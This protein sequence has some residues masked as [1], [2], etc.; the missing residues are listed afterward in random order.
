M[1]RHSAGVR[2]PW[3]HAPAVLLAPVSEG[4]E[5]QARHTEGGG[6]M[7]QA[8]TPTPRAE[9]LAILRGNAQTWMTVTDLAIW[10]Y[11]CDGFDDWRACYAVRQHIWRLRLAGHQIRTRQAPWELAAQGALAYQLVSEPVVQQREAA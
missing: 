4:G 2:E 7:I 11:G 5:P 10:I 1:Q 8:V 6:S 3:R 9:V